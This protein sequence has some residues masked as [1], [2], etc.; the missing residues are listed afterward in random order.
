MRS[1]ASAEEADDEAERGRYLS[2]SGFMCAAVSAGVLLRKEQASSSAR[3]AQGT[4][5]LGGFGCDGVGKEV[6]R[7]CDSRG[8]RGIEELTSQPVDRPL[9][10]LLERDVGGGRRAVVVQPVGVALLFPLSGAEL[11]LAVV[12]HVATLGLDAVWVL[13]DHFGGLVGVW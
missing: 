7:S 5:Q 1:S 8:E 4:R 6:Y 9:L 12:K 3:T 2:S 10:E 11:R 13:T